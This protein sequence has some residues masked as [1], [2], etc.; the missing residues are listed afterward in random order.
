[1]WKRFALKSHNFKKNMK[2]NKF[3]SFSSK[4]QFLKRF[5]YIVFI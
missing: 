3:V 2:N 4:T 5:F 1:M